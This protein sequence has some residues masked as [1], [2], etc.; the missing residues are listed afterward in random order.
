MPDVN[1]MVSHLT[2][3]GHCNL[4]ATLTDARLS[5]A[6]YLSIKLQSSVGHILEPWV[7]Y[8]SLAWSLRVLGSLAGILALVLVTCQGWVGK[9][10]SSSPTNSGQMHC[11]HSLQLTS[12]SLLPRPKYQGPHQR[13]GRAR[14]MRQIKYNKNS[15]NS[16]ICENSENLSQAIILAINVMLPGSQSSHPDIQHWGPAVWVRLSLHHTATR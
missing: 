5:I 16:E 13:S 10:H 7:P 11:A 1:R 4:Q 9:C 12:D 15:E 8:P 14:N 3:L 6:C 2:S